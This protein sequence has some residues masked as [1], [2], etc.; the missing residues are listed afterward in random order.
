MGRTKIIPRAEHLL[1]LNDRSENVAILE[2]LSSEQESQF[3][4]SLIFH[5][6]SSLISQAI[7]VVTA[8]QKPIYQDPICFAR[9]SI[10]SFDV[11]TLSFSPT[12]N[13][14]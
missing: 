4:R 8:Q 7:Q 3:Q 13:S 2:F 6:P 12:T 9:A 10:H 1:L 5:R 11:K 14:S